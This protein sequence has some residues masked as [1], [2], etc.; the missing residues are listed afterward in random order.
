[1]EVHQCEVISVLIRDGLSMDDGTSLFQLIAA[2]PRKIKVQLLQD[3]CIVILQ[4]L[5]NRKLSISTVNSAASLLLYHLR[6]H[7]ATRASI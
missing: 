6:T 3:E 1:M 2:L 5:V 7:E 4:N